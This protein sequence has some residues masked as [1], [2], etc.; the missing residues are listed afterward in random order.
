MLK[1]S[2]LAGKQR[3]INKNADVNN[4]KLLLLHRIHLIIHFLIQYL[5]I[6]NSQSL[7]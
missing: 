2:F 7:F 6:T 1:N 3:K 5:G 4:C